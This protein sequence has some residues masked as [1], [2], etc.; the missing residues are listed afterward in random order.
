[1]VASTE[2]LSV[3]VAGMLLH[4]SREVLLHSFCDFCRG[5][6]LGV[7]LVVGGAWSGLSGG[8]GGE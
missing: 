1:M 3:V 4:S 6:S 7:S 2:Y 8:F 5:A